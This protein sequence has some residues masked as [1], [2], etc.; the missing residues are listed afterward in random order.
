MATSLD[1]WN[2]LL[3]VTLLTLAVAAGI[4]LPIHSM[5][6]GGSDAIGGFHPPGIA[7]LDR[8]G[9]YSAWTAA[10]V[11][12]VAVQ[13]ERLTLLRR[14]ALFL[15]YGV[16]AVAC[17][18]ALAL[19][20]ARSAAR[21]GEMAIRASLGATLAR[22]L[23]LTA[24]EAV[25]AMIPMI[26]VGALAAIGGW[27]A[28]EASWPAGL[29]RWLDV[30]PASSAVA[31]SLLLPAAVVLVG[32][33]PPAMVGRNRHLA[34]LLATGGRA[35]GRS[36]GDT[37]ERLLTAVAICATATLMIASALLYAAGDWEPGS[38]GRHIDNRGVTTF[39]V[40]VPPEEPSIA[41]ASFIAAAETLAGVG[42]A[43]AATVGSWQGLG[44]HDRI[45]VLCDGCV[46][47][48]LAL[49]VVAQHVRFHAVGP[50]YFDTLGIEVAS[51]RE[52]DV[53]DRRESRRVL[54]VNE[55]F[56]RR[57]GLSSPVGARVHLGGL[58]GHWYTIVGV[59]R[60]T[61]A[62]GIGAAGASEPAI[63]VSALQ[64]PPLVAT[65]LVRG[66]AAP[67]EALLRIAKDAGLSPI[68]RVASLQ[69][70]V[71]MLAAPVH[72]FSRIFG[73]LA[74]LTIAFAVIGIHGVLADRVRRLTSEIGLRRALGAR[75]RHIVLLLLRAVAW[76]TI[77]GLVVGMLLGLQLTDVL[78]GLFGGVDAL[79]AGVYGL[80]AVLV[81]GAASL[82]AALPARRAMRIDPAE[83]LRTY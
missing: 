24:G 13:V 8:E 12:P 19:L 56:G 75:G 76:P 60:D 42:S 68:S 38:V 51:G 23:R 83:A 45:T 37:L 50:S 57:I 77:G 30:G 41:L 61:E 18:N 70:E 59:A 71:S 27:L 22:L 26:G 65:L 74:L 53:G 33:L 66:G 32:W 58:Q 64:H 36:G 40:R 20:L 62:V 35:G 4:T 67:G 48:G 25:R 52:F 21:T 43:T 6:R 82:G 47:G 39:T 72:W 14:I 11:R 3:V 1:R 80:V 2:G 69:R 49:P 31:L 29:P 5:A 7:A 55:A 15:A 9:G 17:A 28:L 73:G 78:A 81:F 34:S 54:V 10:A 44:M 63:Y 16:L 46:R 79:D